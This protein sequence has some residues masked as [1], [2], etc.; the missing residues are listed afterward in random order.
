MRNFAATGFDGIT[1]SNMTSSVSSKQ[2]FRSIHSSFFP[3][4]FMSA[5]PKVTVVT[6]G[7]KAE[8]FIRATMESVL[9]QDYPH[10]EYFVIDGG[11]PDSTP[12]IIAEYADRLAWWVSEKDSGVSEAFN[13]GI[14]RSTGQYIGFLNA[15]DYF[16]S[17]DALSGLFSGLSA[18]THGAA[19][20][21]L[22]DNVLPDIVYGKTRLTF[23]N[24]P[25]YVVGLPYRPAHK[26][27]SAH[28]AIYYHRRMWERYGTFRLDYRYA[29]D[30]EHYL[31]F[32]PDAS[33]RYEYSPVIVAERPLTSARNSFGNPSRTY[34]EYLRA[35]REH[36]NWSGLLMNSAKFSRDRIKEWLK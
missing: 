23:E 7:F 4:A 30:Y 3:K 19:E 22:P 18:P 9:A 24:A 34:R 27:P 13:K 20:T 1:H 5:L 8:R 2:R 12:S 16:A 14:A 35:D 6:I 26:L 32:R 15:G 29:M 31:R 17:N 21:A 25:E 11:S 33:V 36:Q 10:L 28:Q